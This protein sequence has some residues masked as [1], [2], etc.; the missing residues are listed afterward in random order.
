MSDEKEMSAVEAAEARRAARKAKNKE[1]ADAQKVIDLDAISE[2][3][4]SLGDASTKAIHVDHKPGLVTI[5]LVRCP[6]KAEI[7]RYRDMTKTDKKGRP[8]DG[9]AAHELIGESCCVYPPAEEFEKLC[10]AFPGL[11]GQC[12]M[13]AVA[14]SVGE[15][16]KAG[17]D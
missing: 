17:K 6:N 13:Q 1:A 14:L 5:A 4:E 2:L 10:E 8:G 3:E 16:E 12:G 9:A 15:E 11:L 7:K